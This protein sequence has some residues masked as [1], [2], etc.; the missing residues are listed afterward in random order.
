MGQNIILPPYLLYSSRQEPSQVHSSFYGYKR[1]FTWIKMAN[2]N[3]YEVKLK[4]CF[5]LMKKFRSSS[6]T[7]NKDHAN[8]ESD[9]TGDQDSEI[10]QYYRSR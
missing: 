7:V 8:R 5:L 6:Q 1:D 2:I 9:K 10:L 3:H 4:I